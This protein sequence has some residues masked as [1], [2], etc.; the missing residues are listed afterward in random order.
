MSTKHDITK[1]WNI[2]KV[3]ADLMVFGL[4]IE[5]IGVYLKYPF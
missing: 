4:I 2:A 5:P 3:K 1:A